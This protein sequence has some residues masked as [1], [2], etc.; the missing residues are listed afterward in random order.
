VLIH[1]RYDEIALKGQRR[2]WFERRL[3]SN[4]ARQVGVSNGQVTRIMGR[5]MVRLEDDADVR[6]ALDAIQRTFGVHSASLVHEVP[7]E[8][9]AI[10]ER[11]VALAREAKLEGART[12]KIETRRTRKDFPLGSYEV[13]AQVGSAVFEQVGL[14]VDV[15]EPDAV[16]WVELRAEGTYLHVGRRPGPGGMPVGTQGRALALISGGIDSPV[17]AWFGLKRGLQ[18]DG[19]YF[20]A[21]PYTGDRVLAKVLELAREVAR[22][23]PVR[24]RVFVASTTRIQDAIAAGA[25]EALRIVL[26][27]RSMYRIA[28]RVARAREHVALVTGESLAQVASQTPENLRCVQAVVPETLVLRPLIGMDK[29][30]IIEVAK[31][32]DTYRTSILPYQDCCSLFAPNNPA[33]AATPEQCRDAEQ[34]LGL[35]AL[36]EEAL[37]AVEVYASELGGPVIRLDE[38]LALPER[39]S[40]GKPARLPDSVGG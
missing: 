33:T 8:M 32:I 6:A 27:R 9:G 12:F 11:A 20:H 15:H 40:G 23:A 5:L 29:I 25:R 1:V 7:R 3:K 38:G 24:T 17:A 16:V 39:G 22:W 14:A 37:A 36:E 34:D 19:L 4:L 35:A 18:V 21:F 31:R 26:L 30:E 28:A 10:T 2:A 13:S